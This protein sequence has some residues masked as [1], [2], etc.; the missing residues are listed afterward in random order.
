MPSASDRELAYF[1]QTYPDAVRVTDDLLYVEKNDKWY[2]FSI[3][4]KSLTG[5][6]FQGK[7]VQL[8]GD[9]LVANGVVWKIGEETDGAS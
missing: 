4:D 6:P 3:H 9:V 2:F 1:Q 5:S 8:R 7:Y